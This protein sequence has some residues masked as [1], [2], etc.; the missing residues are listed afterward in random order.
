MGSTGVLVIESGDKEDGITADVDLIV[1]R[2]LREKGALTF[3]QGV[4][5]KAST[6]LFDESGFDLSIH[7]VKDFS[8]SWVG[9]RSVHAARTIHIS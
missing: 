5:D 9:V 4:V 8:R 7:E 3:F 2:P 1:D 6:I